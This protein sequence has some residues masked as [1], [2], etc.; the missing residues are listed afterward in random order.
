MLVYNSALQGLPCVVH[1]LGLLG[2]PAFGT[3]QLRFWQMAPM[4]KRH[5]ARNVGHAE[6]Y[7]NARGLWD[8]S[9]SAD[10]M[11]WQQVRGTWVGAGMQGR[12]GM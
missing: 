1:M 12:Y 5:G 9:A 11:R 3:I 10:A 8:L 7:A 6:L 2:F 4:G